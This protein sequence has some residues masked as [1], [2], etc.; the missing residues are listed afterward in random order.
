[1][2]N[3]DLA[4]TYILQNKDIHLLKFD[5]MREKIQVGGLEAYDYSLQIKYMNQEKQ[6]LLPYPLRQDSSPENLL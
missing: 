5:L 2:G 4:G 1:M 3:K 6:A